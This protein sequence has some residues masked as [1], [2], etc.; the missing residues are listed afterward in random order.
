M[1]GVHAQYKAAAV[2]TC[3]LTVSSGVLYCA[4]DNALV[5]VV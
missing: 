4:F 1:D 2:F 5:V 3:L